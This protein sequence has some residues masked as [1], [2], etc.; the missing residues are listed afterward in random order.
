MA[1]TD[2]KAGKDDGKLPKRIAGVKIPK[3]LRA[4]AGAVENAAHGPIISAVVVAALISAAAALADTSRGKATKRKLAKL[5]GIDGEAKKA[6]AKKA[7]KPA[8]A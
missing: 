2:K 8:K 5:A 7:G 3:R 1:K 4:A 6:K